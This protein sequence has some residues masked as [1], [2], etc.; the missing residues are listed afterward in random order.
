MPVVVAAGAGDAWTEPISK[1][2]EEQANA[3]FQAVYHGNMS[4][5]QLLHTLKQFRASANK[6]ERVGTAV[7]MVTE[8]VLESAVPL[9][10]QEVFT[11]MLKNMFDEYKFFPQFPDKELQIT[12]QLFGGIIDQGLVK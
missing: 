2:A 3:F 11:C 12:G 7:A 5:D 1:E 10:L 6:R 9:L 8:D 4:V